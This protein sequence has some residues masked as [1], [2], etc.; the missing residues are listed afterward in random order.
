MSD[1]VTIPGEKKIWPPRAMASVVFA[2]LS[3]FLFRNYGQVHWI[4]SRYSTPET[5]ELFHRV[6]ADV[7][8]IRD[9]VDIAYR[10]LA[11]AALFWC[12][13]S[14]TSEPRLASVIATVFTALAVFCAVFIVI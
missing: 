2:C 14:W 11:A 7:G 12:I 10:L 6:L 9:Q 1:L 8:P 4:P 5:K 3:L 13:W